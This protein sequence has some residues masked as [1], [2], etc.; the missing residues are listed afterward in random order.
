MEC[1]ICKEEKIVAKTLGICSD[2]LKRRPTES[3]PF[4][5][6]AHRKARVPFGFCYP[7]PKEKGGVLCKLCQNQCQ[8]KEGQ[9]S[10]CGMKKNEKGKLVSLGGTKEKGVLECYFDPLPTNCVGSWVCEGSKKIGMKNLSIF[11]GSCTFNCLFCQNWHFRYLAKDLEPFYSAQ[12]IGQSIDRDTFCICFFGGD[13][14]PQIY[15]ALEVCK[16][17]QKSK[18]RIC[19]ETNGAMDRGLL[20]KMAEYSLKTQGT[21]KFDLKAFDPNLHY[22]LC[23]VSNQQVLKNF[24]FLAKK[25]L[26]QAK[27]IFLLASTLL[28]PGYIDEKEIENL[29]RFIASL[30]KE[31]PYSL[32]GFFPDF[33]MSDLPFLKKSEADRYLSIAKSAGLKRVHLANLHLLV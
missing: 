28:V 5:I 23:G 19:W 3:Q 20:E 9:L 8:L 24:E 14:S 18:V 21:I 11:Y 12:E 32:L 27:G 29:S 4:I 7:P 26:P 13:P 31:I 25:F 30:S 2:C 10:F 17:A 22:G 1:G 15:H 6:S 16:L 33:L